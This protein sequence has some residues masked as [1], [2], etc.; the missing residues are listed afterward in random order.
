MC[1]EIIGSTRVGR[2]DINYSLQDRNLANI[3]QIFEFI[4]EVIINQ[5][6]I[7]LA[8]RRLTKGLSRLT[9]I[10]GK[11]LGTCTIY[12]EENIPIFD[13]NRYTYSRY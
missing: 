2:Y 3:G 1:F 8:F 13:A 10:T 7:N 9:E 5:Y 6:K 12:S 4:F 11:I